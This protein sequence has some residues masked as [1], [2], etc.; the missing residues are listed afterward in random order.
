MAQISPEELQKLYWN[1]FRER[2]LG[3]RRVWEILAGQFFQRW[4]DPGATV[5]DLGAGYGE[6]LQNIRAGRKLAVDAN[7]H[8]AE[9]WGKGIEA[10]HFDVTSS[11][12]VPGDSVDC[13]FTSNFFEHL[14]DKN[15]LELCVEQIFAALKPGGVLIAMGPNIRKTGGTYWDFFDHFIA[16]TE[17]SLCELLLLQGFTITFCRAG[18]LFYTM[19]RANP[20][21]LETVYPMLLRIYLRSPILWSVFGKQ[22]LVVGSKPLLTKAKVTRREAASSVAS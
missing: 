11:W 18:F 16:L 15:A 17:R 21:L 22:F 6:F 7:R 9:F 20:T 12:P 10:L 4:V 3:R 14:P 8:A 5:L 1:R 13:V 19:S 2:Q